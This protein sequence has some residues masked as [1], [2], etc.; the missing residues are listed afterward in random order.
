MK[1]R[2]L[3]T[4]TLFLLGLQTAKTPMFGSRLSLV[5]VPKLCVSIQRMNEVNT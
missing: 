4:V 2:S 1:T 3:T 5:F